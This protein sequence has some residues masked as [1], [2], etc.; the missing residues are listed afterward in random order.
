[1]LQDKVTALEHMLEKL[2]RAYSEHSAEPVNNGTFRDDMDDRRLLMDEISVQ[3]D[4]YC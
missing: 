2:D 4:R 3:L 1:M